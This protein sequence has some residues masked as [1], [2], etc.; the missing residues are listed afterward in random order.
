MSNHGPC[1]YCTGK[2]FKRLGIEDGLKEDVYV[3]DQCWKLLKNPLTAL[4]LLRGHLNIIL[5]SKTN[6]E[7][8][9]QFTEAFVRGIAGW[10]LRN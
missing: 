8:V 9:K 2:G 5:R 10:K 3:C 4:P 7:K 6:P 1:E